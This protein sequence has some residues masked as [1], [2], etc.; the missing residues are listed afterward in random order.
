MFGHS[1]FYF[2]T[3]RKMVIYFGTIF[4][5]TYITRTD[6]QGDVTQLMRVPLTYS[7][8]D[9]LLLRVDA[10]PEIQRQWA[11]TLPR[12]GFEMTGLRYDE[13]RKMNT[14]GRNVTK[15]SSDA[16]KLKTQYNPVPYD[17][18]FNL[19]IMVKNAEDGT[20]I[21]EQ[22]LPFFTPEWTATVNLIPEMNVT[23]DIPVVMRSIDIKDEYDGNFENRRAIVYTLSFTVKGYLYGPVVSKPIIKLS[24]MQFY[25]PQGNS[26]I[27]D[28]VG[29]TN[30]LGEITVTPGLLANGA[31]TTNSALSINTSLIEVDDDFGFCI[32]NTGIILNE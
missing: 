21:I 32:D 17:F 22:I 31:P 20:K 14:S 12:M 6:A 30:V 28:T 27:V 11:I 19:Y 2:S 25:V 18:D 4:N 16:D 8:K 3:I 1:P 15:D 13:D 10:D 5:D 26:T 7:P 9:K 29:T 23:K 24:K